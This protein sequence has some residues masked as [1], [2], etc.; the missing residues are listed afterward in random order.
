MESAQNLTDLPP[1]TS[2]QITKY[3]RVTD[4]LNPLW[5]GVKVSFTKLEFWVFRNLP[6][7]DQII[8]VLRQT[9]AYRKMRFE[10]AGFLSFTKRIL[11]NAGIQKTVNTTVHFSMGSLDITDFEGE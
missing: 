3:Q 11:K 8:I 9:V 4:T 7:P 6:I 5:S 10:P 2:C 1:G